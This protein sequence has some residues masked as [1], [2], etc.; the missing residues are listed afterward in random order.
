MF[1]A[2]IIWWMLKKKSEKMLKMLETISENTQ[3]I[4][5]TN[6]WWSA[7]K[8]FLKN[9]E[10]FSKKKNAIFFVS[11]TWFCNFIRTGILSLWIWKLATSSSALFVGIYL[12]PHRATKM[13]VFTSYGNVP[14][15]NDEP[16]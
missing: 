11:W 2:V 7:K 14:W 5:W 10:N 8:Y 9:G 3:K 6:A 13:F 15:N 4:I 1:V 16:I 12:I